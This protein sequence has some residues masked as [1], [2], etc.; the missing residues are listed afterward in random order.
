[1][2]RHA[3]HATYLTE[4]DELRAEVTSIINRLTEDRN[5]GNESN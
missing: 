2:N 3:R 1:M 4:Q 5:A